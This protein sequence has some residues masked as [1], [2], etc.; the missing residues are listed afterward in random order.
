MNMSVYCMVPVQTL[1]F[2]EVMLLKDN[3]FSLAHFV[4]ENYL[5][6]SYLMQIE[7]L[8]RASLFFGNILWQMYEY[9]VPCASVAVITIKPM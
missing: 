4:M 2:R 5:L 3:L 6:K 1:E 7:F 8:F 9:F